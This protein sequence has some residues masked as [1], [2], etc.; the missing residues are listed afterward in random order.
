MKF[1]LFAFAGLALVAAVTLAIVF[2]ERLLKWR[3]DPT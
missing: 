3:E 1:A 2:R